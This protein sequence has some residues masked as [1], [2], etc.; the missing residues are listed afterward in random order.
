[1]GDSNSFERFQG[2]ADWDDDATSVKGLR[3]YLSGIPRYHDV[4]E[5][6]CNHAGESKCTILSGTRDI[7]GQ[8]YLHGAANQK[9][10]FGRLWKPRLDVAFQGLEPLLNSKNTPAERLVD[11]FAVAGII[12]HELAVN[13]VADYV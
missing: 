11:T 7:D 10:C 2:K 6:F 8:E 12:L 1:M 3:F 9:G 4:E 13:M 5:Y